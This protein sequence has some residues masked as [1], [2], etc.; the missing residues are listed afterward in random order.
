MADGEKRYRDCMAEIMGV[1]KKYD[2]ADFDPERE[3]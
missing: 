1:L 3:N 2:M